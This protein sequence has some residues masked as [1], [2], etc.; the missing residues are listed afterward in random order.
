MT[1]S[2]VCV[3]LLPILAKKKNHSMWKHF[4]RAALLTNSVERSC[5]HSVV[6]CWLHHSFSSFYHH[7]HQ[8]LCSIFLPSYVDSVQRRHWLPWYKLGVVSKCTAHFLLCHLHCFSY[9]DGW[10]PLMWALGDSQTAPSVPLDRNNLFY[11]LMGKEAIW[12]GGKTWSGICTQLYIKLYKNYKKQNKKK[13]DI[14]LNLLFLKI[15]KK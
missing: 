4:P 2:Q 5:L 8:I 1:I 14:L 3:Y 6:I 11:S 12:I 10:P 9:V 13:Q 15:K 7:H